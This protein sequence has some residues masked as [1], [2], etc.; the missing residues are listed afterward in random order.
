LRSF[1]DVL[2]YIGDTKTETGLTV[3]AYLVTETYDKGVKVPDE[4]MDA[5][6][7]QSH[8]VCPQWNY[9]IHPR[10]HPPPA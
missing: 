9:T 1:D 6:C 10:S 8:D 5:L 3:Q 7:I 4:D 2:Y